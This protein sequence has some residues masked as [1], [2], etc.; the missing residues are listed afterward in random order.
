[1]SEQELA[2]ASKPLVIFPPLHNR[3][4]VVDSVY[5]Q[6]TDG[7]PTT[8]MGD[9]S[10]FSRELQSDEQPYERHKLAK[11]GWEP[12]DHGWIDRCGMLVLRNDEG[13]FAVNPTPEQRAAVFER[14]IEVSFGD[15]KCRIL[16][17]PLETCRF[18]PDDVCCMQLRCRTG[19]ARYTLYLVPE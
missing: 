5:Y 19:T 12:L 10:R 2:A 14:V 17:P 13:H 4:T 1:M 9:A 8:A 18:Y 3:L 11:D 16:V 15:D 7:S 6:P